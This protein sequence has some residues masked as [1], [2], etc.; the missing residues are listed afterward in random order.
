MPFFAK[1]YD[2]CCK[3]HGYTADKLSTST[4]VSM[5]AATSDSADASKPSWMYCRTFM[6]NFKGSATEKASLIK[7]KAD[8]KTQY[9][10]VA[11]NQP[12]CVEEF[13]DYQTT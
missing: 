2:S 6:Y 4:L 12:E 10:A 1:E 3:T 8:L 13:Y 9:D 5:I 11:A 7:F